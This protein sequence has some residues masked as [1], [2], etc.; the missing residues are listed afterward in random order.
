VTSNTQS[1]PRQSMPSKNVTAG[2]QFSSKASGKAA[3]Q[4]VKHHNTTTQKA[5]QNAHKTSHKHAKASNGKKA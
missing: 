1:L 4:P 3:T 5:P 2:K